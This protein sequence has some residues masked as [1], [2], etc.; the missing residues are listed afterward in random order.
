MKNDLTHSDELLLQFNTERMFLAEEEEEEEEARIVV[1]LLD[2]TERKRAEETL[3]E[4]EEQFRSVW[5]NSHDGMRLCDANGNIVRINQAFCQMVGKTIAE[6]EGKP[7]SV[8]YSPETGEHILARHI[9]RFQSD[10]IVPSFE[11]QMTLHDGRTVWLEVSNSMIEIEG[12]RLQLSIFRDSTE[13]KQAEEEIRKY[14]MGME[15]SHESIFITQV[16]GT[17]IY[18]NPAFEQFYGYSADEIVGKTPRVIKSGQVSPEQYQKLWDS[19]LARQTLSGEIV[20]KTKDGRLV[21][22]YASDN[23]ILDA[24]GKLVG[25]MSIQTDLTDRKRAEEKISMLAQALKSIGECVSITDMEDRLLYVNETFC[26][27]Y[28]YTEDELLGKVISMVR[29]PHNPPEIMREILSA[30]IRGGWRGELL[31]LRK[32]SS[33]FPI[34]LSTSVIHDDNGQPIALIGVASDITERKQAEERIRY[35]AY[36]LQNVFDAVIASDADGRIQAWNN[37][38]ERTYG[39]KAEEVLGQKFHD[40]MQPEYSNQSREEVFVKIDRDGIWSGEMMHHRKDGKTVAI[41]STIS[42]LKDTAGNYS[43]RVSVNHDI[44]ERLTAEE[45]I[46]QAEKERQTLEAQLQHAQKLESLGT[47]VSGIAHDFNNILAVILGHASLIEMGG[48]QTERLANSL[49]AIQKA[50]QR[51]AAL[52]KQLLTFARKTEPSLHALSINQII[53]ELMKLLAETFPK[54]IEVKTKFRKVPF[55]LGDPD[56]LYQVILNLCV[57]ARDA[58]PDGGSLTI[59]TDTMMGDA[60]HSLLPQASATEYVR[61]EVSDTGTGMSEATIKRVFDPFFTTKERGKGT[62]LGLSIVYGIVTDH[63]GFILV[64]SALGKGTTFIV[65]LPVPQ[66]AESLEASTNKADENIAGGNE[67]IL[68]VED[69]EMVMN[70]LQE[71]LEKKGYKVLTAVNGKAGLETYREQGSKIDLIISDIGLPLINGIN[72]FER[73]IVANPEV[74]VIIVSG[75]IEVDKKSDLLS[76][77]LKAFIQKPCKPTEVWTRVREALDQPP[78]TKGKGL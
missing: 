65:F 58:M 62:G 2:I 54:T 26:K 15:C 77:G 66:G 11:H 31:N 59:Q 23:P 16:D 29:S 28:G 18:V 13:R 25:F 10:S 72:L 57:N 14:K 46:K 61:I 70:F 64:N 41:Q 33:E 22:V 17:I 8:I 39:W 76:R 1:S 20:N 24:E 30:T 35:Q 50:G 43:G 49:Q 73:L 38:A 27:T 7:L 60:V 63:H 5:E 37:A 19:L 78:S 51:G 9:E 36:L 12:R 52:V 45:A 67:T 68:I 75:Y 34:F 21:T 71:V 42:V 44:T 56:Q 53:E 69:E 40:I 47:L 6:M 55:I 3:R 4:S 48:V 74:K 32:D